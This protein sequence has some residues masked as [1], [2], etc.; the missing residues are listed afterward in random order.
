MECCNL[1]ECDF[2]EC[3]F[4]L[5]ENET[6][7][8]DDGTFHK[9]K[10]GK[11][12]GIIMCFYVNEEPHYEYMP[13]QCTEEE[14]TKWQQEMM[15]LHKDHSWVKNDFWYLEEVSC[16]LIQRN[17]TWFEG[18]KSCFLDTW[19][20]IL[21]ERVHGYEHRKK[22]KEPKTVV[23]K[24]EPHTKPNTMNQLLFAMIETEQH[25]SNNKN[26]EEVKKNDEDKQQTKRKKIVKRKN[27][28]DNKTIII[29][30]D[31]NSV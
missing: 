13:F 6:A 21:H 7:F 29:N 18:V 31:T 2:L 22:K 26:K 28:D 20:T 30:I 1:Y 5:Y 11:Y 16:V 14:C 23:V 15:E 4:K 17:K 10:D 9:T 12:K 25:E 27:K 3:R 19:K 8:N 24:K